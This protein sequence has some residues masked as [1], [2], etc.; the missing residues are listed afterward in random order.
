MFFPLPLN[1][2]QCCYE[3]GRYLLVSWA[4]SI[5]AVTWL[6]RK[7]FTWAIT[8]GPFWLFQRTWTVLLS[9]YWLLCKYRSPLQSVTEGISTERS[10]VGPCTEYDSYWWDT[11]IAF[12]WT[13]NRRT[14]K[15]LQRQP[16]AFKRTF[17]RT[18]TAWNLIKNSGANCGREHDWGAGVYVLWLK[19]KP[20]DR[21]QRSQRLQT[22]PPAIRQASVSKSGNRGARFAF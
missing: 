5:L 4:N 8:W 13:E 16:I 2:A 9:H 1:A 10:Q 12:P 6:W 14:W 19:N 7:F 20:R 21:V 3:E 22:H 15:T 11:V 18:T 17:K